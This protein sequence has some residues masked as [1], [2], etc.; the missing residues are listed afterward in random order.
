[1]ICYA[2]MRRPFSSNEKSH[3]QIFITP[4]SSYDGARLLAAGRPAPEVETAC[5]YRTWDESACT[6]IV[7]KV[8]RFA[9]E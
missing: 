3:P 5:L 2:F 4:R 6:A 7:A 9:G 8:G 1:M